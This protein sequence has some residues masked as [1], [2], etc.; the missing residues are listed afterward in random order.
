MM[1]KPWCKRLASLL[2]VLCL[3]LGQLPVVPTAAED[4]TV[5]DGVIYGGNAAVSFGEQTLISPENGEYRELTVNRSGNLSGE[6]RITLQIYDNSANYGQDYVLA[7][8]GALLEKI[9]GS[10]SIYD[11]FRDGGVLTSALPVEAAEQCIHYN[12]ADESTG[13]VDSSEILSRFREL[14]ALSAQTELC[15]APG[16]A[17]VTVTVQVIDDVLSEYD[18]SFLAILVDEDGRIVQ[19]GQVMLTITDDEPDPTVRVDF[20][21]D[22]TVQVGEVSGYAQLRFTRTGNLAVGTSAVLLYNGTAMGYV[23]FSPYQD[24]QVVLALPGRYQLASNGDYT[25]G[26]GTVTVVGQD[27]VLPEGADPVLDAV[28][29]YYDSLP[30]Q[31][32]GNPGNGWLPAWAKSGSYEDNTCIVVM[33]NSGEELFVK[34]SSST[35]GNVSYNSSYNTYQL[36]TEGGNKEGYLFLRSKNTYDLSG[37]ESVEGV[38][39]VQD[40]STGHCDLIFGVWN[41]GHKKIYTKDNDSVHTLTHPLSEKYGS[42]RYIY[43]CNSDL[44]GSWDCGWN[45]YVPNGFKMNKRTY[46]ILVADPTPLSFGG[47]SVA[48][49]LSSTSRKLL[50]TMGKDR[51]INLEA[52]YDSNYPMKLV[53]FQLYDSKTQTKSDVIS[54]NGKNQITFDQEFLNRYESD[55]CYTTNDTPDGEYYS[56]FVIYPV[57][58]KIPV[59]YEIQDSALGSI[60]LVE[61][62]DGQL[63]AS[64]GTLYRG[65]RAVFTSP[66]NLEQFTGVYYQ[67]RR[68]KGG[69]I[70]DHGAILLIGK[71]VTIPVLD[72][73]CT[74]YTFQAMFS[75]SATQLYVDYCN[76]DA[77]NHGT[78]KTAGLVVKPDQY[79]VSDYFPLNAEPKEGYITQWTSNGRIYYGDLFNYQLDGKPTNNKITVD[80]LPVSSLGETLVTTTLTGYLTRRDSDLQNNSR[81]EVA[82]AKTTFAIT[83]SHGTY[84]AITDDKGYFQIPNFTGV[85]GG[86]YSI[87]VNYQGRTGFL[88][89]T[90]QGGGEHRFVMPQFT[91]GG[92]FPVSSVATMNG[93]GSSS[94]FLNI[95]SSGKVQISVEVYVHDPETTV[96]DVTFHFLSNRSSDYG[97]EILT[98]A[99]T[100]DTTATVG[101]KYQVWRLELDD[102]TAVPVNT[103]LYVSVTGTALSNS[104]D[105]DGNMI[106]MESTTDKVFTGYSI[107]E[108]DVEFTVPIHQDIPDIPGLSYV[109]PDSKF[110]EKLE[111]PI[112][113]ALDFTCTSLS[114]GYFKQYGTWN[115]PGDT[116]TLVLGYSIASVYSTGTM[117]EKFTAAKNTNTLLKNAK[118]EKV[119]PQTQAASEGRATAALKNA[120]AAQVDVAPVFMVK[121]TVFTE[122][123]NGVVTGHKLAGIEVAVG[124]D[125]FIRK[126]VPFMLGPV[127]CYLCITVQVELYLQ[128]QALLAGDYSVGQEMDKGV[129]AG[130][131]HSRESDD[132]DVFIAAPRATFGVKGGVGYNGV[133]SVFA[134]GSL[135]MPYTIEFTPMD[136][137]LIISFN[138]G[139]GVDLLFFSAAVRYYTPEFEA[140]CDNPEVLENLKAI[141]QMNNTTPLTAS[142]RMAS[143]EEYTSMD[144]AL[145][146]LTFQMMERPEAQTDLLRMATVDEQTLASGVFKNTK[147]Q[148]TQLGDGKIMALF[149]VDNR[150]EDDSLNY[151]SAAYAISD[152]QGKTWSD[153]SYIDSQ[154][155]ENA[156][157]TQYDIN[158][159]QLED[160][161][162]VTWSQADMD[163]A[164]SDVDLEN[165]TASQMAKAINSMNLK[166]RFFDKNDG[167]PMGEPFTIAENSTVFCGALDAVQN[168]ENVYVYYQRNSMPTGEDVTISDL[169]SSERTIAMAA[170]NVEDPA[171]WSSTPVRAESYEGGQYR[172]T[173]VVPFVH[174]GILGE[175][176]VIDRNGLLATYD[177]QSEDLVPD[178]EDR[179]MFLRTYSFDA[180]GTPVPTALVS[181]TDAAG[182]DQSPQVVSSQDNLYLFWNHDGEVV[183]M[184][185]FVA[186]DTDEESVRNGAYVIA[187]ADGSCTIQR[188]AETGYASLQ[189]HDSFHVGSTFTASMSDEGDVLLCWVGTDT[190]DTTLVPTD[191]IYGLMLHT[192]TSAQ[193]VEQLKQQADFQIKEFSDGGSDGYSLWASGAPVALTDGDR[194][195]GALDGLH[196]GDGKFLLAYT[197]M[198]AQ[199]RGDSVK[200]DIL[201][202]TRENLPELS[203]FV[204]F[205]TYPMPGTT[206]PAQVTV[207]N[208]GLAALE[209]GTITVSGIG[210][211]QT[212]AMEGLIR[213][214]HS[215]E[216]T[217]DVPVPEDFCQDA[218]LTVTVSDKDNQ[219]KCVAEAQVRY[220][221]YM[222]PMGIP[223]VTAI[224]NTNNCRVMQSVRNIGNTSG[225]VTLD[226]QARVFASDAEGDMKQDVYASNITLSPGGEA[227]VSYVLNDTVMDAEKY[228]V[229]Q[230]R[231]GE[232]HDQAAEAAMPKPVTL[233][234]KDLQ[235]ENPQEPDI[236]QIPETFDLPVI[237][238]CILVA[239]VATGLLLSV[240]LDGRRRKRI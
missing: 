12:P 4:G 23:D 129:M 61:W 124:L 64:D 177:S 88:E 202:Q 37:I 113:G 178:V 171:Q 156:M 76:S 69:E 73:R 151:I 123:E 179:Q 38:M 71:T 55:W 192:M 201:T 215:A 239:M 59:E 211:P 87:S 143:G 148:L 137:G 203:A 180:D 115:K 36:N 120:C 66:D 160:R 176:M 27:S 122:G 229:L 13:P 166:G 29:E 218:V 97:G 5:V 41:T 190:Q 200:A 31:V 139:L 154:V 212:I 111:L 174:D 65:D 42:S 208:T 52:T 44:P 40:L 106:F 150:A 146:N 185:D 132:I 128:V 100:Q 81:A 72:S 144:E 206:V 102:S 108:A 30:P 93:V 26:D 16:E 9:P 237:H 186:R 21:C 48:P 63:V 24:T 164:L 147:I 210:Q 54:L 145:Q 152:D 193:V 104:T 20:D 45:G 195:I 89:F 227:T 118:A 110:S 74:Y 56:T 140:Y 234:G 162:L 82:L 83:T 214:G 103:D 170:A 236:P 198:D 221:S 60:Q 1:K 35:D 235:P 188:P 125:G 90:Y 184:P 17:Q 191:E 68:D 134:E 80:F 126:N 219:T 172:I 77:R 33:G 10:T 18:E 142:Y 85:A 230:V 32:Q 3:L 22:T 39:N 213:P 94:N 141:Q 51:Q 7:Y 67:G 101:D 79:D 116:Y 62:K 233:D 127:P 223:T 107:K 153:F 199:L 197:R 47:T 135:S 238:C 157:A 155:S 112:V 117:T 53:G 169:L 105:S 149:L 131:A 232:A 86:T 222:I 136:A 216:F 25:V 225:T 183:Y 189:G 49:T 6:K 121:F 91:F 159:Y 228:C 11:A 168:G 14:G 163:Q 196:L 207:H 43:Y 133:A 2:L 99:A 205:E 28:P 78:L 209:G 15:F 19:D 175:I 58:E 95:T 92:F 220:G 217:V 240:Y 226:M 75:T 34:D 161:V 173:E 181:L 204:E 109:S 138:V 167:T 46:Y 84:T 8:Q 165:I 194:P 70:L 231:T 50:Y 96:K 114:G 158:I 182:C 224:P 187:N 130:M 98:M 57:F 119:Q